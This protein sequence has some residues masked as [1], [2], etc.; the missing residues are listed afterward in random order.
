MGG[1]MEEY[2]SGMTDQDKRSLEKMQ[3]MSYEE[4]KAFVM[5]ADPNAKED[6]IKLIYNM[7]KAAAGNNNK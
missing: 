7:M 5:K 6:E 4:F 2:G 1:V 3:K